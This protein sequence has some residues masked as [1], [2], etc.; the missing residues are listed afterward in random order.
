M[1]ELSAICKIAGSAMRAQSVRMRVTSENMANVD[2]TG[3]APGADPYRRKTVDFAEAVDR[4]SGAPIVTVDRI[5]TD[6]SN[7]E[8]RY[9]PS[10]PA[11]DEAGYV[12]V[13]N[14]NAMVELANMREAMRSFEANLNMMDSGRRMRSQLLDLL[15]R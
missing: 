10:H 5:G 15:K 4:A 2:T 11:A 14:V 13:P 6:P 8:K 9:D 7:F 1:D 3:T 12:K